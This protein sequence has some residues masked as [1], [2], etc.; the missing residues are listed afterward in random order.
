MDHVRR[1]AEDARGERGSGV[2]GRILPGPPD[3]YGPVSIGARSAGHPPAGFPE[4]NVRWH[5]NLFGA[6]VAIET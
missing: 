5:F 2:E 6:A 1:L 4:D 3:R